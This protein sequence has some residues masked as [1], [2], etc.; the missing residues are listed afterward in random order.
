MKSAQE[1]RDDASAEP[2]R[3][4]DAQVSARRTAAQLAH[5][6]E[7]LHDALHARMT[8]FVE[9]FAFARQRRAARGSLEEARVELRF[10]LL[11]VAAHRRAADAE[12]VRRLREAAFGGH[13]EERDDARVAR[14]ETARE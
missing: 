10:E 6:V 9:Q 3:R 11:H 8:V 14:D 4:A 12:P 7:R 13:R 1:W 2:G 5:V